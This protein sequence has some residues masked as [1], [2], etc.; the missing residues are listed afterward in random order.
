MPDRAG[1]T[2]GGVRAGQ[3]SWLPQRPLSTPI[4]PVLL[5]PRGS[6]R[7]TCVITHPPRHP[8]DA[9]AHCPRGSC[10]CLP[11]ARPRE[12]LSPQ[13][14]S[15]GIH[16]EN[17][18]AFHPQK[19]LVPDLACQQTSGQQHEALGPI[20]ASYCSEIA[21]SCA[22]GKAVLDGLP[23]G[24]ALLSSQCWIL[25]WNLQPLEKHFTKMLVAIL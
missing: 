4:T 12:A 19:P 8:A 14:G 5:A 23:F 10:L 16:M 6:C 3:L 24:R 17:A 9:P 11:C 1:R 7:D 20:F 2:N 25:S 13:P 18:L 22:R 15:W 21:G